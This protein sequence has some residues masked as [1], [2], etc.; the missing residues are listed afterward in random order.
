MTVS[1]AVTT[2]PRPNAD[3]LPATLRSIDNAGFPQPVLFAEPGSPLP[4]QYSVVQ[5]TE[6]L[7]PYQNFLAALRWLLRETDADWLAVFQDDIEL[8]PGL[9]PLSLPGEVVSLYTASP[10]HSKA[11]GW[12][13]QANVCG[14]V[15]YGALAVLMVRDVAARFV[16]NPPR[17]T[18][19]G[20]TDFSIGEFCRREG[21]DYWLHSPSFCRHQGGVSSI[22]LRQIAPGVA[23]LRNCRAFCSDIRQL[24]NATNA[25]EWD[26]CALDTKSNPKAP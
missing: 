19:R 11:P 25:V 22:S 26:Q 3:Y 8:T 12:H 5:N 10:Y 21:L 15:V 13:R 2:S 1:C 14:R 16:S 20:Q 23:E 9:W 7:G 18:A 24:H 6:S 4:G 17:R